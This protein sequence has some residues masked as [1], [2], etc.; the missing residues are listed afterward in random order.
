VQLV[1]EK[2]EQELSMTSFTSDVAAFYALDEIAVR[3]RGRQTYE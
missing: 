3:P 1:K 2:R